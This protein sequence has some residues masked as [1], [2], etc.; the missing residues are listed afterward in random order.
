MEVIRDEIHCMQA[1]DRW[2]V[3]DGVDFAGMLGATGLY[4][5]AASIAGETRGQRLRY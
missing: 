4:I 5:P 2:A 3:I 1:P